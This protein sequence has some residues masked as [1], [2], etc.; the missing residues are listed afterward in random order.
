MAKVRERIPGGPGDA[1]Q[2]DMIALN[3]KIVPKLLAKVRPEAKKAPWKVPT[4]SGPG[5]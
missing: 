2:Q 5:P 1:R 4:T 3:E